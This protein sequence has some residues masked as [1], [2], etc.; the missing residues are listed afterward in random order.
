M[1]GPRLKRNMISG[2]IYVICAMM[3]FIMAGS[4]PQRTQVAVSSCVIGSKLAKSYD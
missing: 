3:L 2:V 1:A 4:P